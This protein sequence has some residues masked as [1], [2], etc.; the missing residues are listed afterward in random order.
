MDNEEKATN[1]RLVSPATIWEG[2]RD[3][4]SVAAVLRLG[5]VVAC[6]HRADRLQQKKKKRKKGGKRRR[7]RK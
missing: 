2:E 1:L 7:E 4:V 5:R 6:S 3:D